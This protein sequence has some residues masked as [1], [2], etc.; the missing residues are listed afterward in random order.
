M[1]TSHTMALGSIC[2][3]LAT[4]LWATDLFFRSD[5]LSVL[6]PISLVWL[7]H[8]VALMALSPLFLPCFIRLFSVSRSVAWSLVFIGIGGSA[9]GTTAFSYAFTVVNPVIPIMLQKLQPFVAILGANYIL[10]EKHP[11]HFYAW[12]CLGVVGAL[13]ISEPH[14]KSLFQCVLYPESCVLSDSSQM[15][16]GILGLAAAAIAVLFWGMSTVF[17]RYVSAY[18]KPLDV[19]FGRYFFGFLG[20]FVWIVIVG[21]DVTLFEFPMIVFSDPKLVLELIYV[22]L[23]VGLLALYI[24]YQG[25]RRTPAKLTALLELFYPVFSFL[26]GCVF[27]GHYLNW[28]QIVG[29]VLITIA[30]Y[31]SARLGFQGS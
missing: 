1:K 2:I 18:L 11:S 24:Y 28:V 15:M 17:G 10:K 6:D 8:L 30:S 7:E 14:F 4:L 3:V 21:A 9:L 23:A 31:A 5:L 19:T 13:L 22:S 27:L 25:L 16:S 29:M 20:L 12:A 26:I